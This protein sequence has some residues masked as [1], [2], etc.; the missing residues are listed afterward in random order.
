MNGFNYNIFPPLY[1]LIWPCLL[2]FLTPRNFDLGFLTC[3][4][5]SFTLSCVHGLTSHPIQGALEILRSPLK[6][7]PPRIPQSGDPRHT[8]IGKI[9]TCCASVDGGGLAHMEILSLLVVLLFR[10]W[11]A[12]LPCWSPLKEN[13]R[14]WQNSSWALKPRNWVPWD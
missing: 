5:P 3:R 2:A 4:Q 11:V 13:A 9:S 10:L 14:V 6:K 1:F 8:F 12:L 7:S